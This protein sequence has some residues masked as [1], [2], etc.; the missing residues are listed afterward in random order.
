MLTELQ[1][2]KVLKEASYS[3]SRSG[4]KGGQNVNKLETKV[5]L[6]FNV[7]LSKGLDENQKQIILSK[8][9]SFVDEHVIKLVSSKHRT[10]LENK[11]D[12]RK[13]LV[14]LLNKLLKPV[15]KRLATKPSRASKERKIE[16]K[17]RRSETKTLRKK[18][19]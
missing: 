11:E 4:G 7:F 19:F 9:P 12:V 18:I 15:K 17:K 14:T 10:Q 6:E 8:Y 5:E 1:I 2:A 3:T 13:K 16:G